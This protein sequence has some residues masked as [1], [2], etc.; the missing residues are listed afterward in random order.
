MDEEC[1]NC[2]ELFPSKRMLE[3]H[4]KYCKEDIG[5]PWELET[6]QTLKVDGK[7]LVRGR[8]VR[9]VK[10]RRQFEEWQWYY[11]EELLKSQRVAA[12]PEEVRQKMPSLK[13][14]ESRRL[15]YFTDYETSHFGEESWISKYY[16]LLDTVE[17]T[18]L[19]WQ[20]PDPDDSGS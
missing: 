4:Q 6:N 15:I 19:I 12:L 16:L 5:I 1:K 14:D 3:I 9:Q 7:L 8:R 18:L 10:T 11:N 17:K 2:G 13:I 20:V